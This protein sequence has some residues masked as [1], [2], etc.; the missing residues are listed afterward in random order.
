[1]VAA[2][3]AEKI[4]VS[5]LG[6]VPA[7]GDTGPLFSR[8]AFSRRRLSA[9]YKVYIIFVMGSRMDGLAHLAPKLGEAELR[10]ILE[11][12]RR[13][14]ASPECV[15]ASTRDLANGC[16]CG[17]PNVQ[18][19]LASL[20]KRNLITTRKGTATTAAAY[21]RAPH[22]GNGPTGSKEGALL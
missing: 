13:E 17:R 22:S 9:G 8:G 3:I 5:S 7:F 2:D 1:V 14:L 16:K 11:L 21:G 6:P 20:T 12:S 15:R 18:K 19:A 4:K 10:L